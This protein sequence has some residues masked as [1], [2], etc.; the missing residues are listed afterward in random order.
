MFLHKDF[1]ENLSSLFKASRLKR[2]DIALVAVSVTAG[3]IIAP[4]FL[5]IL[6]ALLTIAAIGLAVKIA[7][8]TGLIEALFDKRKTSESILPDRDYFSLNPKAINHY[9][10][11]AFYDNLKS[12]TLDSEIYTDRD[13]GL[14][15]YFIVDGQI[16][17]V[18]QTKEKTLR[19]RMTR[20]QD[21]GHIGYNYYI[22]RNMLD[23]ASKGRLRIKTDRVLKSRLDGYEIS[24]IRLYAPVNRLW[25]R[26]HNEHFSKENYYK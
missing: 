19:W 8:D 7:Y 16:R 14:V 9:W 20:K 26:E 23:A 12:F 15:Y 21:S 17:Y 22:K 18:G 3:Y 5:K 4:I 11:V 13:Y 2:R 25:N 6:L 24:Q 10:S 1:A